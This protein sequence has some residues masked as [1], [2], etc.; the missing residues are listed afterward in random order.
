M[1][2]YEFK[3][4][5]SDLDS[6]N[7]SLIQLW[8]SFL[9]NGKVGWNYR[10]YKIKNIIN[11]GD[12]SINGYGDYN[13]QFRGKS[14]EVITGVIFEKHNR[15]AFTQDEINYFIKIDQ[16]RHEII[17]KSHWIALELEIDSLFGVKYFYPYFST[18]LSIF[19]ICEKHFIEFEFSA[20]SKE[21]LEE[22]V[23]ILIDKL[24]S[25][26]SA[27]TNSLIK[28]KE[29]SILQKRTQT[30][31][32]FNSESQIDVDWIDSYPIKDHYFILPE[33][34]LKFLFLSIE[35][36]DDMITKLLRSSHHFIHGLGL[37]WVGYMIR[38]KTREII[39]MIIDDYRMPPTK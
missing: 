9:S 18:N 26:L 23:L 11:V 39:E 38:R 28:I 6:T 4:D 35:F 36:E 32:P 25:I 21:H 8:S 30:N 19:C 27:Q 29:I 33:Y 24:T 16:K 2:S 31:L 22:R 15:A 14:K 37:Q 17:K 20:Y 5:S 1:K 3:I 34:A 10:P 7:E 13:V 12:V